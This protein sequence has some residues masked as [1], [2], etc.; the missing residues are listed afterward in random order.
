MSGRR[1]KRRARTKAQRRSR[2]TRAETDR[3]L[4]DGSTA[5]ALGL[6]AGF[7]FFTIGKSEHMVESL[8]LAAIIVSGFLASPVLL[9][10]SGI[11]SLILK[12]IPWFKRFDLDRA[13]RLVD[14]AERYGAPRFKHMVLPS[15]AALIVIGLAVGFDGWVAIA[16]VVLVVIM[17]ATLGFVAINLMGVIGLITVIAHSG[18][19]LPKPPE[20]DWRMALASALL[21]GGF[22]AQW[23]Q[24]LN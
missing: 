15:L 7:L 12:V 10:K 14:R 22:L 4:R 11:F 23:I 19:P 18:Q 24:S 21:F 2:I 1:K 16:A 8:A 20:F 6:G 9:E 13:N 5:L 17:V 3:R